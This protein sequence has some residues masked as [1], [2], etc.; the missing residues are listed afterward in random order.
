MEFANFPYKDWTTH[1]YQHWIRY[2][3]L[4]A[5]S[6]IFCSHPPPIRN[7]CLIL[8]FIFAM[9]GHHNIVYLSAGSVII[10]LQIKKRSMSRITLIIINNNVCLHQSAKCSMVTVCF[11][12]DITSAPWRL[13]VEL[14]LWGAGMGTCAL[15]HISHIYC[16]FFLIS[17][18][19]NNTKPLV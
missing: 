18:C 14:T 7:Q 17:L 11:V 6:L 2:S 15:G 3:R 10:Y 8:N 16:G 12:W 4:A 9:S 5:D 13:T 1:F 19:L